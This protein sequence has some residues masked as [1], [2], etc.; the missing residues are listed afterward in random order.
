[1]LFAGFRF[2][3]E[4]VYKTGMKIIN[5]QPDKKKKARKKQ[6]ISKNF[7]KLPRP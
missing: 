2:S 6:K 4:D 3:Q 1:M 5:S 7:P